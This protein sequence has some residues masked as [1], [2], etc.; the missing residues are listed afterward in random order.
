MEPFLFDGSFQNLGAVIGQ[1]IAFTVND[2]NDLVGADP[3]GA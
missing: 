3:G 2:N 1:G